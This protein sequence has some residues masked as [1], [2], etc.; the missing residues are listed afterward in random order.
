M[1]LEKIPEEINQ[2]LEADRDH[3]QILIEVTDS[4]K[5]LEEAKRI[6]WDL[7]IRIAEMKNLSANWV[8]LKLDVKDMRDAI[9]KLTENGFVNIKGINALP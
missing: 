8:L 1:V 5:F 9:L 2:E 6:F 7:G 3:A 4:S